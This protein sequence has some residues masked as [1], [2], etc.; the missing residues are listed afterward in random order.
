MI[1]SLKRKGNKIETKHKRKAQHIHVK[2]Q[3][4]VEVTRTFTRSATLIATKVWNQ[5][6]CWLKLLI[7]Q[8][9]QTNRI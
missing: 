2:R 7:N 4:A 8:D 1:T 6:F 9:V 5:F 3:V